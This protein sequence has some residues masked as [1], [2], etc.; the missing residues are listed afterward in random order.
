MESFRKDYKFLYDI[1]KRSN[2]VRY[3]GL[4][5]YRG[6]IMATDGVIAAWTETDITKNGFYPLRGEYQEIISIT[7]SDFITANKESQNNFP[8][9]DT[10]IKSAV[11][12][13]K[14]CKTGYQL[15]IGL[16]KLTK[17]RTLILYL[18]KCGEFFDD[19]YPDNILFKVVEHIRKRDKE[20]M[21]ILIPSLNNNFN[22]AEYNNFLEIFRGI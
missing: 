17:I 21:G 7:G 6:Y 19:E 8:R 14:T 4:F 9:F 5:V 11:E 15:G 10:V 13:Y 22:L 1:A 16:Y 2:I 12:H 3:T 20:Y 18:C